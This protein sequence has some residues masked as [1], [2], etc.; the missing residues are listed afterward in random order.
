MISRNE[1]R[2]ITVD[3]SGRQS[4]KTS[5]MI[6]DIRRWLSEPGRI[7]VVITPHTGHR[8]QLEDRIH[9]EVD[10]PL[11][12]LRVM[13]QRDIHYAISLSHNNHTRL[14]FDEF[15]ELNDVEIRPNSYYCGTPTHHRMM[16][17]LDPMPIH[18]YDIS[19]DID[20]RNVGM[21]YREVDTHAFAEGLLDICDS[22]NHREIGYHRHQ[23]MS[24]M[25][26]RDMYESNFERISPRDMS[27]GYREFDMTDRVQWERTLQQPQEEPEMNEED[28]Y[29]YRCGM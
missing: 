25:N 6:I 21:T 18:S 16:R 3:I 14:Y 22:H 26:Y 20:Y 9:R 27:M 10:Y 15:F 13:V 4:G 11:P 1:E 5:R 17:V 12:G 28:S 23:E 24:D 19:G 2:D 8:R 29:N 7:A